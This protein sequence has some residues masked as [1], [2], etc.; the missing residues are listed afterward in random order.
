MTDGIGDDDGSSKGGLAEMPS[1][2]LIAT[3]LVT[4]ERAGSRSTR[5]GL[6]SPM[7]TTGRG[8]AVLD[9]DS[10]PAIL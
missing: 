8:T 3:G 10:T 7:G 1:S 4:A 5:A 6:R 9:E 2:V